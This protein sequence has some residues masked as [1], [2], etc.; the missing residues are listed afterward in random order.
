MSTVT[1]DI[2][3]IIGRIRRSEGQNEGRNFTKS[4]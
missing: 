2:E 4:E 3:G 1:I